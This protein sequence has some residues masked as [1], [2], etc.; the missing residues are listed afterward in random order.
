MVALS[1]ILYLNLPNGK[2][3]SPVSFTP[4]A[5]ASTN[6]FNLILLN[7]N[8]V[9]IQNSQLELMLQFTQGVGSCTSA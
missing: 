8:E 6:A 7:N 9:V 5:L 1:L 3:F 2:S 4:F